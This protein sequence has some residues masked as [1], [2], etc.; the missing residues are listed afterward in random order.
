LGEDFFTFIVDCKDPKS[1]TVVLRGASREIINETERNLNDAL[2]V[3]RNVFLDP[4]LLTGGGSIEM[5]LSYRLRREGSFVRVNAK[6]AYQS[7]SDSLEVIPRT[8]AQSSGLNIAE[9]LVA[10][11]VYHSRLGGNR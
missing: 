6:F 3:A 7:I 11:R 1:C 10:L 8:L 2:C 9:A 5:Y 4:R